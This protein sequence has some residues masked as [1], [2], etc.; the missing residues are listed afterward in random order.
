MLLLVHILNL[1]NNIVLSQHLVVELHDAIQT[2][3][4]ILNKGFYFLSYS[5]IHLVLLIEIHR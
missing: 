5:S 2:M 3:L 4:L 1:Y